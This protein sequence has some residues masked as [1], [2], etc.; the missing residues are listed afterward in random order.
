MTIALL[1]A[2]LVVIWTS[3]AAARERSFV[4]HLDGAPELLD[5]AKCNNLRCQ[6]VMW[7]IYE[8]L[9]DLSKDRGVV[10]HLAESWSVSP[11][12]LT[13]TFRLRSGVTLHDGT[14]FDAEAAKVNL[15]RNYV[16]GSR[17]YSSSPPNVR[18]KIIA[19]LIKDV[20]ATNDRTLT[21]VLKNRKVHLLFLVP[22]VSPAALG[23][24]S[25]AVG[26]HPVGTGPFT[27][28]RW[29][30]GEIQLAANRTYWAGPPRLDHLTF[31][32][33]PDW[34]LTMQE[35]KAGR[36]DFLREIEPVHF[37][38]VVAQPSA[39]I[40]RIPT[41][42]IYYLGFRVDRR[43]FSDVRIRRAFA[44][45]LNTERT[46]LFISRGMGIP[47]YGPLPP[48]VEA[49]DAGL[50]RPQHDPAGAITLLQ[51]VGLTDLRVA[52]HYNADWGFLS[53]LSEAIKAD[54]GKVG[55]TLDLVP[56]SGYRQFLDGVRK[57]EADLF[58]YNWFS[59]FTDPEIFLAPLFQTRSVDNLTHYSNPKVD[60]LLEEARAPLPAEARVQLYRQAQQI[61]VED[62]PMVFL[63]HKVRVSAYNTRLSGLELNVQSFPVD[64]FA[65]LEAREQ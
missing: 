58:L 52:L 16:P 27:F 1:L 61:V 56:V 22:M 59:H 30:A 15:E 9:V 2:L 64:R 18:E 14:P 31:K 6:A 62:A 8:P 26:R 45:A 41:L 39:K 4:Y 57:G 40:L 65:R 20:T 42:S 25:D 11:D 49:Y 32:I 37:E 29:T 44:K 55:V 17:F 19:G 46:I 38:R 50:K 28:Q 10:P 60:A 54:L 13:Y 35:F 7:P 5:P 34:E 33:I 48:G 12:G 24:G 47:A 43:P 53:E 51:E 3:P 21:V 36:L 23:K 63:F